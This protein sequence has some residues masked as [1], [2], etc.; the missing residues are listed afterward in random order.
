MTPTA[1]A[2]G[3]TVSSSLIWKSVSAQMISLEENDSVM[4]AADI[5]ASV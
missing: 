5:E 3:H 4:F 2:S 1:T